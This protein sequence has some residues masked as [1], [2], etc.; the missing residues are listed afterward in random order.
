M[1]SFA[2]VAGLISTQLLHIA[3]V[4]GSGISCSH[5][6]CAS[7]PSRNVDRGVRQEVKRDTAPASPSNCGSANADGA[8]ARPAPRPAARPPAARGSVPHQPPFSCASV[9]A[10]PPSAAGRQR[11]E[12]GAEHL[13]EGLP[14]QRRAASAGA[15]RPRAARPASRASGA[16]AASPAAP[17]WPPP[18]SEP[19]SGTASD[20]R[21]E[22]R[23]VRQDQVGER[24]GLVEEAA[25]AHDER[26]LLERLAHPPGLR[27]REHRV[28][29]VEQQHLR[30]R[31]SPPSTARQRSAS[32]GA[33]PARAAL[34]RPRRPTAA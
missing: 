31:G 26:H 4:S 13:L 9:H 29:A 8:R 17:R 16:A 27:R 14:R 19:D 1:P 24:A 12:R 6:R 2:A 3:E 23:V 15:G 10:S 20:P 32:V 11:G 30:R 22:E 28:R 34:A 33:E 25:E 18:S 7:D 5:G 21:F